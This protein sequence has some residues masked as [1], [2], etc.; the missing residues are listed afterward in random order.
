MEKH[1]HSVKFEK[2]ANDTAGDLTLILERGD[3]PGEVVFSWEYPV[4]TV[5]LSSEEAIAIGAALMEL[6]GARDISYGAG[7]GT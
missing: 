7:M 3:R 4:G 1:V 2:F 5:A 6:G